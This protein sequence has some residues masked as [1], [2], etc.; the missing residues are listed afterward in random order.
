[1]CDNHVSKLHDH[2]YGQAKFTHRYIGQ[3]MLNCNIAGHLKLHEALRLHFHYL[4]EALR[5][6]QFQYLLMSPV[7]ENT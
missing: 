7:V 5:L 2:T 1:M 4:R 3:T 6:C